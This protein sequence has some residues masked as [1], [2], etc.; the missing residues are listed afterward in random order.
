MNS[1]WKVATLLQ[2]VGEEERILGAVVPPIFQNSTFVF[3]TA[4]DFK[5]G[6][7][8][9]VVLDGKFYGYS[10][11]TNPTLNV[12]HQKIAALEHMDCAQLFSSGSGAIANAILSCVKAGSHVVCLDTVYGPTRQFLTDFLG[13]RYGV[14]TTFVVG[15]DPEEIFQAVREDT[16]LIFLESPGSILFLMQDLEAV[17]SFA[18]ERGITTIIDNSYCSPIFQNPA[19]F[20]IDIVCHTASKY[21]GGHS[22]LTG[23]VLCTSRERMSEVMKIELSLIGGIMSPLVSWLVLRG[24]R[25]LNIRLHAV[26][27][28]ALHVATAL[29]GHSAVETVHHPEFFSDPQQ[30]GLYRKQMRGTG[31]LFSWEPKCQDEATV[32]RFAESLRVFRM[33]VSWGGHESLVVP[34]KMKP[35]HWKEERWVIRLYCG[36]EDPEDQLADVLR[37]MK[38][39]GLDQAQSKRLKSV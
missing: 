8:M 38:E 39:S 16:D 4:E 17:A 28:N 3:D 13:A 30:V 1:D 23:G 20:G 29:H 6:M 19:D 9:D 26:Q 22:D 24:L 11:I 2:H 18:R 33:G 25:T 34:I 7:D 32:I 27:K 5:V 36:L 37:A 14:E 35:M 15:N 12:A 10:R 21:L 31:G